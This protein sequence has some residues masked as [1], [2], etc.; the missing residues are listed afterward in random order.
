[1]K[2]NLKP[3]LERFVQELLK[4]GR[5]S[6]AAVVLEA[7]LARLM[8]DPEPDRLDAQD[9]AAIAASDAQFSS[10]EGL[11]WTQVKADLARKYLSR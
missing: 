1:M 7:G 5:F 3:E 8:L 6:S 10:G 9:L 2:L 4:T 11:D